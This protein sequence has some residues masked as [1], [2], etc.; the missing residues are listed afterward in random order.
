MLKAKNITKEIASR[1]IIDN[2]SISFSKGLTCIVGDSGA[3]KSTLLN[4]LGGL[5]FPSAGE[6][7]LNTGDAEKNIYEIDN[8]QQTCLGFVFQDSNLISGLTV[9]ENV[10][11]A[12]QISGKEAQSD[13]VTGILRQLG[14]IDVANTKAECISGGEKLRTAIARAII[15]NAPVILA[16]EP[17]GNLDKGNAAQVFEILKD[18]SQSRVV[19]VVTHNLA[20]AREYANRVVTISDGKVVCDEIIS[21]TPFAEC[22]AFGEKVSADNHLQAGIIKKLTFNNI[23]RFRS[24]FVLSLGAMGI[25]LAVLSIMV[26]MYHTVS[27]KTDELNTVYYD[28]DLVTFYPYELGDKNITSVIM[29]G[30]YGVITDEMVQELEDSGLFSEVIPVCNVDYYISGTETGI[31]YKLINIDEFFQNRLMTENVIGEFPAKSNQVIIAKDMED[32]YFDGDAIGKTLVLSSDY[33]Y[34]FVYEIVGVNAEKNV[35]GICFT[36]I[37]AKSVENANY[38]NMFAC[39]YLASSVEDDSKDLYTEDSSGFIDTQKDENVIYG[40]SLSGPYQ[41]LISSDMAREIY[42]SSTGAYVEISP[43]SISSSDSSVI[44]SLNYIL[45]EEYYIG[46]ND[47]YKCNV[48]GI[49][50]GSFYKILVS[51]DWKEMITRALPNYVE[52]YGLDMATVTNFS[53]EELASGYNYI[54]NYEERFESAVSITGLWRIMFAVIL[55]AVAVLCTVMIH[56]YGKSAIGGRMYEA[57]ILT[58][59]GMKKDKIKKLLSFEL[60]ILAFGSWLFACAV[61]ILYIAIFS[62]AFDNSVDVTGALAAITGSLLCAVLVS[63]LVAGYET[64]KAAKRTAIDAIRM[65]E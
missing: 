42:Y 56:S 48:V 52:C 33:G 55:I 7:Y 19:V 18:I 59:L 27:S 43:G 22:A 46:A 25:A 5:D 1:K 65:R 61:Y 57:G 40:S 11:L 49:H 38:S 53:T 16:D 14:L 12:A 45:S 58:S 28:A 64:G 2:I 13:R 36:Y 63:F 37:P 6:I 34:D 24:K 30:N 41:I 26:S 20:L 62:M 44:E 32:A 3:G 31:D 10:E 21:D 39:I 23:K 60:Y 9:H 50:D 51:N 8:Y 47:A 4:M 17:T 54:S 29:G 15:K 35:D